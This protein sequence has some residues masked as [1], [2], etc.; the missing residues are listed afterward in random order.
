MAFQKL[1]G[2]WRIP[3]IEE[4]GELLNTQY[5]DNYE[6]TWAVWGDID[7]S[8]RVVCGWTIRYKKNDNTITIPGASVTYTSGNSGATLWS[9]SLCKQYPKMAYYLYLNVQSDYS[10]SPFVIEKCNR[11]VGLSIRPVSD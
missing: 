1:G 8:G 10:M 4:I 3:T 9:S 6:W 11:E 2:N 7:N 5:D